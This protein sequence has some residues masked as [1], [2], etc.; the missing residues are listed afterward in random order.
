MIIELLTQKGFVQGVDYSYE[1]GELV[2]LEQTRMI[3]QIDE[4]TQEEVQVEEAFYADLPSLASLKLEAVR[5]SDSALLI[6][7]Y[8]KDKEVS[9]DDS[10][11]IELFLNGQG[12]WRFAQVAAPSIDEL[13]ELIAPVTQAQAQQAALANQIAS[14]RADRAKCE[15]A[16]DYI[17]GVNRDREL[18]IEQITQMQQ[19]FAQAEALL[20]ASRPD[21]ASMVISQIVPDSELV[22][23]EMKDQ[24]LAILA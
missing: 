3:T 9:E 17:A 19:T 23:Q 13:F 7:E 21:F 5:K 22:T 14:G 4:D 24:V 20:R 18:T 8:L 11:N 2:A 16:L 10:L 12:G 15:T 6:G 1:N